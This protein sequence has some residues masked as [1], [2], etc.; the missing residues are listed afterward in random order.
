[1]RRTYPFR[2]YMAPLLLAGSALGM[3]T[4]AFAASDAFGRVNMKGAIVETPCAIDVGDRDQTLLMG[5]VPIS[6]ILRDGRGPEKAFTIRLFDCTLAAI[7]PQRPGWKTFQVTFDGDA[8]NGHFKTLGEANGIAMMIRDG[9]G[10]IATPGAALPAG[11]LTPGDMHLRYT[12]NLVGNKENLR[13]G[14]Y[15]TTI[16]FRLDYN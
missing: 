6:Q 12:L 3:L 2:L 13:A 4:P 11:N 15:R 5:T 10:N 8:D 7:N 1:M 9:Q 14:D 16:R